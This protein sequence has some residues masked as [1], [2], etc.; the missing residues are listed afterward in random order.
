M[1]GSRHLEQNVLEYLVFE[2][3]IVDLYGRWRLQGKI[4][5][6]WLK[7]NAEVHRSVLIKEA[8]EE[9]EQIKETS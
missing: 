8:T 5:P 9:T 1:H 2:K 4:T 3:N 7:L 6:D